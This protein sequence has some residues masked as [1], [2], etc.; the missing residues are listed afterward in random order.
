M[1]QRNILDNMH[2]Y[3]Y[4]LINIGSVLV[5]FLASFYPKHPFYKNWKN[6][7]IANTI[8]ASCFIVWDIL[9]TKI[10]VWGFNQHYLLG[11]D[12]MGI[13][14]EE[15]LFFFCIPYSSVFIY[16][17]LGYLI[18]NNP[19]D[20]IHKWLTLSLSIIL[21]LIAI[22]CFDKWYT[23]VT[24]ILTALFLAY[25]YLTKK[26]LSKVYLSYSVTLIFFF[27]VNG[28]LTGSFIEAPV[29]W[30]NNTENLGIR[31]GT[32]P[33]EDVFYGFLLIASIIQI[34]EYLGR[35]K[36]VVKKG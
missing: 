33:I 19:F 31:L 5:P 22:I 20:K 23:S 8:V 30:Y 1:F 11:I 14:L 26:S 15:V 13:P 27:I 32:I 21:G 7:I 29:V 3:L 18:Q 16:F 25:N 4:L 9:F 2:H 10:G 17:A 34:F 12:C 28:I 24:F 36:I 35:E 6:Y